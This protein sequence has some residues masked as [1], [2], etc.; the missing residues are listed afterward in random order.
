MP[1]VDDLQC[2]K[3]R[4][5]NKKKMSLKIF[6]RKYQIWEIGIFGGNTFNFNYHPFS[7]YAGAVL[8]KEK[9]TRHIWNVIFS[10]MNTLIQ[11]ENGH[12][13]QQRDFR[14]QWVDSGETVL[15][16]DIEM[17]NGA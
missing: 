7:N 3:Y 11:T 6:L 5:E 16:E 2:D 1:G 12:G 4:Q 8:A 17:K 14:I 10:S 13:S 15:M 9:K